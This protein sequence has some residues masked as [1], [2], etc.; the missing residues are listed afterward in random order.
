MIWKHP[1]NS[2]VRFLPILSVATQKIGLANIMVTA[3]ITGIYEACSI[4]K[5][6]SSVKSFGIAGDGKVNNDPAES[7]ANDATK[8]KS[9][10]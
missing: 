4:V 6:Y 5:L 9:R 2:S 10:Q 7:A 1:D 8:N 3:E